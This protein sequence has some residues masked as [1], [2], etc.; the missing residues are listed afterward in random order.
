MLSSD[1]VSS[2]PTTPTLHYY[3]N[4][5]PAREMAARGNIITCS[6]WCS[7]YYNLFEVRNVTL[8]CDDGFTIVLIKPHNNDP[9]HTRLALLRNYH[10]LK[11]LIVSA[12]TWVN[13]YVQKIIA[14]VWKI[15][16]TQWSGAWALGRGPSRCRCPC[17]VSSSRRGPAGR[18]W[19]SAWWEE[20]K[21]I[22][23][24]IKYISFYAIWIC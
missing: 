16:S 19:A 23:N 5:A 4:L 2:V 21:N 20:Y 9:P 8:A 7:W 15:F 24:Y 13:I 3:A 18:V 6:M 22:K 12:S 11:C 14:R 17:T 10:C 1:T